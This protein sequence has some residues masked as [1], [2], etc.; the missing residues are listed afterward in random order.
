MLKIKSH[1]TK[2][3]PPIPNEPTPTKQTPPL[4]AIAP[5]QL[6]LGIYSIFSLGQKFLY[7]TTLSYHIFLISVKILIFL[8]KNQ[9]LL[10]KTDS[11]QS[12]CLTHCGRVLNL[13]IRPIAMY[14]ADNVIEK[15]STNL[16]HYQRV[17]GQ[18]GGENSLDGERKDSSGA[19]LLPQ[20]IVTIIKAF[21]YDYQ[22][23]S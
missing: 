9:Y 1:T 8:N 12:P 21:R 23:N 18:N 14:C 22:Y 4:T 2:T 6:D 19:W 20:N 10:I 3:K 13:W 7:N 5:Q 16:E 17:T 15:R 11:S